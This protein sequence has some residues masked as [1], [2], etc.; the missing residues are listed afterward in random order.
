MIMNTMYFVSLYMCFVHKID[1]YLKR[2]VCA[3]TNFDEV[4][5]PITK[6]KDRINF[7]LYRSN[8]THTLTLRPD[9]TTSISL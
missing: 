5:K 9:N 2:R 1:K 7:D 6:P 3:S 4:L 8:E